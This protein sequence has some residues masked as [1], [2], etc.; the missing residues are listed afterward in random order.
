MPSPGE[1]VSPKS[2]LPGWIPIGERER[3]RVRG[4]RGEMMATAPVMSYHSLLREGVGVGRNG[5]GG[6]RV[7]SEGRSSGSRNERRSPRMERLWEGG[8]GG[9][10]EDADDEGVGGRRG[11]GRRE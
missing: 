7:G 6:G 4:A 3:E 5:G 11:K 1:A 8:E 2:Q 10:E 9:G